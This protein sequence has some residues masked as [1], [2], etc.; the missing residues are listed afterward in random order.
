[1]MR[2]GRVMRTF[3]ILIAIL[4]CSATASAFID[5]DHRQIL[6]PN[7]QSRDLH[8]WVLDV[9]GK[10]MLEHGCDGDDTLARTILDLH[11][12]TKHI[13]KIHYSSSPLVGDM[14]TSPNDMADATNRARGSGA[15]IYFNPGLPAQS[16][17][18][19]DPDIMSDTE[20][21]LIHELIHAAEMAQ[22]RFENVHD[23]DKRSHFVKRGTT[24]LENTFRR[25]KY[26]PNRRHYCGFPVDPNP[27]CPCAGRGM[28]TGANG[29]D[30]GG[31]FS[32]G[33]YGS[34]E[35][36]KVDDWC[37][38]PDG[39]T[40]HAAW[41][42]V[43][44]PGAICMHQGGAIPQGDCKPSDN[45]GEWACPCG[46]IVCRGQENTYTCHGPGPEWY[47]EFK[48]DHECVDGLSDPNRCGGCGIVCGGDR[49]ICRDAHCTFDHILERRR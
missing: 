15:Q 8:D 24:Y 3:V 12:D 17:K 39:S 22:G 28:C 9:I 14:Q 42:T 38:V 29:N 23:C 21:T 26:L 45:H 36:P 11:E 6:L 4:G 7:G 35:C 18:D 43:K 33:C 32:C 34:G 37:I 1:M 13:V 48:D 10:A 20:A 19:E 27:V 49:P 30:A 47:G 40:G 46:T 44:R 16:Y 5:G 41:I 2:K 25:G 31:M